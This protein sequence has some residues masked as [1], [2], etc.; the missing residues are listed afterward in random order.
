MGNLLRN[1]ESLSIPIRLGIKLKITISNL[2]K[3]GFIWKVSTIVESM[4]FLIL[5]VLI[6]YLFKEYLI[7]FFIIIKFR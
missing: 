3:I 5:S 7:D 2:L 1:I 6:I 4:R